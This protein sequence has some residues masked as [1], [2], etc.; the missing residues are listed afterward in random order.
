[1]GGDEEK[2]LLSSGGH[3]SAGEVCV[4]VQKGRFRLVSVS[5]YE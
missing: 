1:V 5:K 4:S 2:N 3:W